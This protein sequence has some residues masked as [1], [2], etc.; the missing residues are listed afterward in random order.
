M[1][2]TIATAIKYNENSVVITID[3]SSTYNIVNHEIL[4]GKLKNMGFSPETIKLINSFLS[5]RHQIVYINGGG[6]G[7]SAIELTRNIYVSQGSILSCILF[8]IF[9]L[10][11]PEINHSICHNATQYQSCYQPNMTEFV[12]HA[13]IVLK[14]RANENLQDKLTETMTK[15]DNY[16]RANRL[17]QNMVKTKLMV[18]ACDTTIKKETYYKTNDKEGK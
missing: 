13:I 18:I 16:L 6:G 11:F 5:E 8:I 17:S 4:K 2:D 9:T 3:Q 1:Q 10:K 12:D 14:A 7:E 15:V